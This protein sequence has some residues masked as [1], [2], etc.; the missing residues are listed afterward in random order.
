M[1]LENS[2]SAV[3]VCKWVGCGCAG[4]SV[5]MLVGVWVCWCECSVLV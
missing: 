3:E 5:G 1:C 4:V 2:A